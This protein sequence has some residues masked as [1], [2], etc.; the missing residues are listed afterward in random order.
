[1]CEFACFVLF[2]YIRFV[3]L[4][5]FT[6]SSPLLMEKVII[7]ISLHSLIWRYIYIYNA[8]H[9]NS[10][11]WHDWIFNKAFFERVTFQLTF[12]LLR[13]KHQK[14]KLKEIKE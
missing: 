2:K 10:Q 3:V 5:Y 9:R 4:V 8:F 11:T 12:I 14:K 1:M 6:L 13:D 7:C